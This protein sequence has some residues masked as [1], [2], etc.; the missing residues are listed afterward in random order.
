MYQTFSKAESFKDFTADVLSQLREK[1]SFLE[2]IAGS[3]SE[4]VLQAAPLQ[5]LVS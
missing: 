4:Y 3:L 5:W 2:K 1:L